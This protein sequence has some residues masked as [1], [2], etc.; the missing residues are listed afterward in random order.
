MQRVIS[1]VQQTENMSNFLITLSSLHCKLNI[2]CCWVWLCE[3]LLLANSANRVRPRMTVRNLCGHDNQNI[4]LVMNWTMMIM[5]LAHTVI[6]A[7]Q[8][9]YKQFA[10]DLS[11][12][13]IVYFQRYA[14]RP[15]AD[16][17][18]DGC[19][20]L[21]RGDLQLYDERQCS[22]HVA[23]GMQPRRWKTAA[24]EGEYDGQLIGTNRMECRCWLTRHPE[25]AHHIQQKCQRYLYWSTQQGYA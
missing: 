15:N 25:V 12:R 3:I 4:G 16:P 10:Y 21:V 23:V 7:T 22:G 1:R 24:A 19:R 2:Q 6:G 14:S 11:I 13:S 9:N 8:W 18:P 20:P 17:S 5:R